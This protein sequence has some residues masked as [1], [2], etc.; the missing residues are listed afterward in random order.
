MKKIDGARAAGDIVRAGIGNQAKSMADAERWA[1]LTLSVK[2]A[3]LE[4]R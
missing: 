3:E 1:Q 4:E 2:L